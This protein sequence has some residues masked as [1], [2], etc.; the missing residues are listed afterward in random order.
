M[1]ALRPVST[2]ASSLIVRR[3]SDKDR[4]AYQATLRRIEVGERG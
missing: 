4:D 2:R 1:A 3:L